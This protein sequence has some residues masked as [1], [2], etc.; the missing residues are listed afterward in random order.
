MTLTTS[1]GLPASLWQSSANAIDELGT[2]HC[3]VST[4]NRRSVRISLRPRLTASSACAC[5]S[6]FGWTNRHEQISGPAE[7][8]CGAASSDANVICVVKSALRKQFRE[9]HA[10]RGLIEEHAVWPPCLQQTTTPPKPSSVK[11]NGVVT[12]LGRLRFC[13]NR[14]SCQAKLSRRPSC[15][16]LAC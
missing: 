9:T 7:L 14:T 2:R 8:G 11:G 15:S 4:G 5:P 3:G 10:V 6:R 12:Y 1:A 16:M 13:K